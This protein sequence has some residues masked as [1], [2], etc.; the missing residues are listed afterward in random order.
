MEKRADRALD[1]V[2]IGELSAARHAWEGDP[3]A[4]GN[5]QTLNALQDPERRSPVLREI[6]PA[7]I[8][9]RVPQ[10]E[11][12]LEQD[13]FLANLRSERRAAGGLSGMTAKHNKVA[14]ES[15]RDCTSCA[16]NL[17]RVTCR[18]RFSMRIGRMA[19]LQKPQGGIRGSVVGDFT[20]ALQLGPAVEHFSKLHCPPDLDASVS[21]TSLKRPHLARSCVAG[22]HG[23]GWRRRCPPFRVTVLR[24]TVNV[25]V[26]R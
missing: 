23:G 3:V 2:R 18:Q 17:Q 12:D 1:L 25:F 21:P 24:L 13:R 7:S 5:R 26:D 4:P 6:L 10:T 9:N 19:A 8:V 14:L 15:E 20:L 11:I 22:T 16:K